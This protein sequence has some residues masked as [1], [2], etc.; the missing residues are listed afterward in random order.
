M[1]NCKRIWSELFEDDSRRNVNSIGASLAK[2]LA[3][4]SHE[5]TRKTEQLFMGGRHRQKYGE[6]Q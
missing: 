4:G 1:M 2:E 3:E 5:H 6:R